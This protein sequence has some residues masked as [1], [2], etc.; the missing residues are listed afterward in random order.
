MGLA[1][2]EEE[3]ADR[4]SRFIKAECKRAKVTYAELAKRLEGHGVKGNGEL[5]Q[6]Q[7]QAGDVRR[8]LPTRNARGVGIGRNEAGRPIRG[9][10][11]CKLLISSKRN[12]LNGS[13]QSRQFVVAV[14]PSKDVASKKREYLSAAG[15]KMVVLNIPLDG[16][17]KVMYLF[18]AKT[19]SDSL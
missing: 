13:T 19:R 2:T 5:D 16:E 18:S 3:L 14:G 12:I 1:E 11:Y 10:F 7:A 9:L 8:Y 17:D 15:S 4:A 6:V